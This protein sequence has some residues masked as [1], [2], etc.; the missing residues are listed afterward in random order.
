MAA[1][2]TD[3]VLVLMSAAV[4]A[5]VSLVM[6]AAVFTPVDGEPNAVAEKVSVP[7]R[8]PCA[9]SETFVGTEPVRI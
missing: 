1:A 3:L 9:A 2:V 7:R 6:A 5:L 8:V 4:S